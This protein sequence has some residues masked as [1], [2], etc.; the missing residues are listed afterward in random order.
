M[1]RKMQ[2]RFYNV[3]WMAGNFVVA[4]GMDASFEMD[5]RRQLYFAL[6]RRRR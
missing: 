3:I 4:Q 6:C 5:I 2:L 1:K